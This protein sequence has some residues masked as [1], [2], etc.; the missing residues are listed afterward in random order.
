MANSIE[1]DIDLNTKEAIKAIDKASK[2]INNNLES[3]NKKTESLERTFKSSFA[4]ISGAIQIAIQ[5][6]EQL[7][8]A[9][10]KTVGG[11]ISLQKEVA[12]IST[13]FDKDTKISVRGVTEEV[14]KL[15]ETFGGN[16]TDITK[17]FYETVSSGAIKAENATGLLTIANKL[18]VG[19]VTSLETAADGLTSVLNGYGLQVSE[20]SRVSDVFFIGAAA[21]KTDIEKLSK[22][23]ST[24]I[25]IA[26]SLGVNYDELVASISALTSAGVP[27]SQ[28]VTTIRSAITGLVEP[29]NELQKVMGVLNIKQL[30]TEVQTKGFVNTLSKLVGATNGSTESI[31]A[32]L[33]RTEG[34][35]PLLNLTS[36]NV[37]NIF[38]DALNKMRDSSRKTG[39]VTEDAFT[40]VNETTSRQMEIAEGRINSS[41]LRIGE[42]IR[43]LFFDKT[44]SAKL[45]FLEFIADFSKGFLLLT[46]NIKKF[47]LLDFSTIIESIKNVTVV[48]GGAFLA[49]KALEIAQATIL[50]IKFAGGIQQAITATIIL[51]AETRALA[52]SQA[53]ATAKMTGMLTALAAIAVSIDLI[54]R[55]FSALGKIGE[56][57]LFGIEKLIIDVQNRMS[58]FVAGGLALLATGF[59]KIA[60]LGLPNVS[61]AAE[62]AASS[63]NKFALESVNNVKIIDDEVSKL[64]DEIENNF[65]NVIADIDL[66][67][68]GKINEL[69]DITVK[70]FAEGSIEIS[71]SLEKTTE[72]SNKTTNQI[73]KNGLDLAKKSKE[74]ANSISKDNQDIQNKLTDLFDF[75]QSKEKLAKLKV[76]AEFEA[77]EA[78][79]DAE[80]FLKDLEKETIKVFVEFGQKDP[81]GISNLQKIEPI[82]FGDL[83][84]SLNKIIPSFEISKEDL[85][86]FTGQIVGALGTVL[87]GAQGAQKLVTNT[88]STIA[89]ALLPGLGGP[90]GEIVN[91][92]SLGPDKVK[93]LIQE[94]FRALP[95]IITN[96]AESIPVLVSTL[97]IELAKHADEI[98]IAIAKASPTIVTELAKAMPEVAIALAK[99]SPKIAAAIVKSLI[100]SLIPIKIDWNPVDRKFNDFGNIIK[101]SALSFNI[102]IEEAFK[103]FFERVGSFFEGMAVSFGNALA[104][105]LDS[106]LRAVFNQTL[107]E[108]ARKINDFVGVPITN[109]ANKLIESINNFATTIGDILNK[110]GSTFENIGNKISTVFGNIGTEFSKTILKGLNDFFISLSVFVGNIFS[111]LFDSIFNLANNINSFGSNLK[112]SASNFKNIVGNA[113]DNFK[114]KIG[115]GV[116]ELK[117]SISNLSNS[118]SNAA[119]DFVNNLSNSLGR[120]GQV[121]YNTLID[122][123]QQIAN[124]FQEAFGNISIPGVSGGGGVF[125][126]IK[127][128]FGFADGGEIPPGFPN[129]SFPARLTSGENVLTGDLSDKLESFLSSFDRRL[130]SMNNGSSQNVTINLQ[131]GEQQLANVMLNLNKQGFRLS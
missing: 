49:F 66:G 8:K 22:E 62:K 43:Q 12:K 101:D 93:S 67:G 36:G 45:A 10:E 47:N 80:T 7:N 124:K 51:T 1:L 59:E 72:A 79:K 4:N 97:I 115:D 60:Q 73:N 100:Q 127:S 3:I 90:I 70:S 102:N 41:L 110:I 61:D 122:I 91:I 50:F 23:L 83:S 109:A 105:L 95:T 63:L 16:I 18:A 96:I 103:N 46:D 126:K 82:N 27:T 19:G 40:K 32:L 38:I 118:L 71:G 121:F 39:E 35:I 116:G 98:I 130:L 128:A 57:V 85:T 99:E 2:E 76:T 24:V 30:S 26:K 104:G 123:P 29:T 87:S 42:G 92:L 9:Y 129:D 69:L 64:S 114:N 75:L 113:S 54:V 107:N 77:T 37:K 31:G 13:L 108:L 53:L 6:Q 48:L 25:P 84:K 34:L 52:I 86:T 111:K 44:G 14:L 94:F 58:D 15:Q 81:F 17:A 55:N 56:L 21:G 120:V 33:G 28:A 117:N 5:A 74:N 88:I 89:D 119:T 78:Q 131:V 68:F 125:G 20:A 112:D 106:I 11:A 65:S